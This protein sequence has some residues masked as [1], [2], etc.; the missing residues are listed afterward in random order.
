MPSCANERRT[1]RIR[2]LKSHQNPHRKQGAQLRPQAGAPPSTAADCI[3][4]K[5]QRGVVSL[6][7]T[8]GGDSGDVP[9]GVGQ[10]EGAGG[11]PVGDE[12]GGV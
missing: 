6:H 5:R 1:I 3:A 7:R 8:R 12:N 11:V 10:H 2:L 4:D 9:G